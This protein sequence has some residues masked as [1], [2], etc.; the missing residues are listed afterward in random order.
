MFFVTK[1]SSMLLIGAAL[2]SAVNIAIA[3]PAD[4]A[5]LERQLSRAIKS[6]TPTKLKYFADVND[7]CGVTRQDIQAVV[8]G[9]FRSSGISPVYNN[10]RYLSVE[11]NCLKAESPSNQAYFLRVAFGRWSP[12]PAILYKPAIEVEGESDKAGMLSAVELQVGE[13]LNYFQQANR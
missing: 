7:R 1:R 11:L 8:N 6:D 10:S 2:L 12:K 13:A 4:N 5:E 3:Q 9:Q